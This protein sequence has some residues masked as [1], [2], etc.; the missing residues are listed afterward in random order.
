MDMRMTAAY[1]EV[2]QCSANSY[3]VNSRSIGALWID[4]PSN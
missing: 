3:I 4:N 2:W 1:Q